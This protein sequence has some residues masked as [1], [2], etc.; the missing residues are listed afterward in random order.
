MEK[1]D[2]IE[3]VIVENDKDIREG[4]KY[5]L[6]LDSQIRVINVYRNAEKVIDAL[7]IIKTP[8]II[9]MDIGLPKMDGIE[10][11]GIIKKQYPGISILMLT[12]FEEEDKILRAIR[13][14]ADGYVLKNTKGIDLVEQIKNLYSGGSPVSPIVARKILQKVQKDEE[15]VV[16]NNYNLTRRENE[17]LKGIIKG[18]T[19]RE[20]AEENN[21]AC[22]TVKKHVLHIYRKLNVK[23]KVEFVKKVLNEKLV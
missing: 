15:E 21:I 6:N 12:I 11:T 10:A 13:A 5:L 22:S 19:Y 23:S 17:I 1:Q 14:G 8:N 16:G 18:Y 7:E 20:V 4:L 2:I 3:L 9:L